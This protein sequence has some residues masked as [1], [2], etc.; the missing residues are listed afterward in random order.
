MRGRL[1][2]AG[3]DVVFE[4]A[5]D[6]GIPGR[7]KIFFARARIDRDAVAAAILVV[8]SVQRLMDVAD[9]MDQECEIAAGAPAVEIAVFEALRIFVDFRG[10]AFAAG[11]SR[12]NV[13]G[14]G[15][16]DKCR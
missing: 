13:R 16:A 5:H 3:V 4:A 12:G 9:K 14:G 1:R 11:A 8:R 2:P 7:V 10:H 15:P 6:G